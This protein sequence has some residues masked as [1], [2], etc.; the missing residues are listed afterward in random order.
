MT[1]TSYAILFLVSAMLYGVIASAAGKAGTPGAALG[2]TGGVGDAGKS[3]TY[4]VLGCDKP[5]MEHAV[6]IR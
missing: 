2:G 5:R 3:G 4:H 6:L 1:K